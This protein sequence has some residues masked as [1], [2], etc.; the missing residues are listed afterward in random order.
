V[1]REGNAVEYNHRHDLGSR[2]GQRVLKLGS[3]K[4]LM[5]YTV[6]HSN[7]ARQ[8]HGSKARIPKDVDEIQPE[9]VVLLQSGRRRVS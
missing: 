3:L 7:D 1:Y 2:P 6:I 4:T 9:L 8:Y 5:K